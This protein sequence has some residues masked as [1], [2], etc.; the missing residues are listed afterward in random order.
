MSIVEGGILGAPRGKIA[1]IVF[2]AARGRQGKVVTARRRVIPANP[3][4][5]AQQ[6]QRDRFSVAL[7]AVRGAGPAVY[8]TDWNRSIGQLPGFQSLQSIF[9][10][11][12][13]QQDD[14]ANTPPETPLG[15]LFPLAQPTFEDLLDGTIQIAWNGDTGS[16]GTSADEVVILVAL[17]DIQE[18]KADMIVSD[19]VYQRN[20]GNT[21]AIP[22]P[23]TPNNVLI[24]IYAR[25]A[26]TAEGLVSNA[27]WAKL[28][29]AAP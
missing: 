1:D 3:Q 26:G 13:P 18:R 6:A 24:A 29:V 10:R 22:I 28:A 4:T 25:G 2:G 15:E 17:S 27:Q 19:G 21:A 7:S 20:S 14:W 11:A 5:A 23:T 8:K 16:N 12:E 9:L